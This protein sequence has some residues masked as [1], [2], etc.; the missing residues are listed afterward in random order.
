M[1]LPLNKN[2]FPLLKKWLNKPHL[3]TTFG[4]GKVWTDEMVFQ[5]YSREMDA[6]IIGAE[7]KLIGY[8]QFYDA[9]AYPREGYG[10]K[11]VLKGSPFENKK[12][13]AIDIFI[14]E[15]AFLSKGYGSKALEETL[16]TH[17]FPT[18]DACLVDPDQANKR[19]IKAY[20]KA[21]F[22]P[23]KAAANSLLLIKTFAR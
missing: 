9:Y 19:A 5:K 6:F 7:D 1:L 12:L 16:K 13:A 15:E 2:H 11:E 4:E 17:I 21:G 20:M 8:L 10:L 22:K 3:Q 18:F 14:G 23:F